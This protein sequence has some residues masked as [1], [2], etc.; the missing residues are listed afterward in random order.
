MGTF[1]ELAFSIDSTGVFFKKCNDCSDH[2]ERAALICL[3]TAGG[4]ANSKYTAVGNKNTGY[5]FLPSLNLWADWA[6]QELFKQ[7]GRVEPIEIWQD[8]KLTTLSTNTL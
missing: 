3:L 1:K 8:G 6:R 7:M 4:V 2:E 5:F